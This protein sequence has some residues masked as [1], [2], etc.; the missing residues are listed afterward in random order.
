MIWDTECLTKWNLF[1]ISIA[2]PH[3]CRVTFV[4]ALSVRWVWRVK[5]CQWGFLLEQERGPQ[6]WLH[7]QA[8]R[9]VAMLFSRPTASHKRFAE[10]CVETN[11]QFLITFSLS[12]PLWKRNYKQAFWMVSIWYAKFQPFPNL[13]SPSCSI[14]FKAILLL[15]TLYFLCLLLSSAAP[16]WISFTLILC[17]LFMCQLSVLWLLMIP[18]KVISLRWVNFL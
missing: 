5:L 8:I 1:S 10:G 12:T 15:A 3:F 17:V 7:A 2:W 9:F 18:W 11:V 14:P 6:F 16:A 4:R 13:L